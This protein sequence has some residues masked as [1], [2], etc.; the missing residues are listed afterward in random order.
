MKDSAPWRVVGGFELRK[1]H[2]GTAYV[3]T[4][5]MVMSTSVHAEQ[6]G[7]LG[8][9]SLTKHTCLFPTFRYCHEGRST[10]QYIPF[11]RWCIF[12]V[13]ITI[14]NTRIIN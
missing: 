3:C 13:F 11:R 4:V 2:H 12:Q 10:Y 1:L 9:I 8:C 14:Q 7:I 6:A 5:A